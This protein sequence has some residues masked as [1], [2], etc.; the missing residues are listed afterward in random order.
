MILNCMDNIRIRNIWVNRHDCFIPLT[1]LLPALL[2][3]KERG[4]PAEYEHSPPL[5]VGE[6][7]GG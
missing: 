7:D 2:S 6:G 1:S 3:H 4:E 5:L